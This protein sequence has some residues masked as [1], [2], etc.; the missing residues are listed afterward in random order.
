MRT[1]RSGESKKFS[2]EHTPSATRP[3]ANR[4][5]PL[6]LMGGNLLLRLQ[7]LTLV[8]LMAI[9]NF[10]Q[11]SSPQ[12]VHSQDVDQSIQP[13][14]DFYRFANGK[15][16]ERAAPAAEQT[17]LDIRAMLN[18]R[19]AQRVR[20]LIREAATSRSASG[21]IQQKVGDYYSGFVDQA[22]IESKGLA[23]LAD[24]LKEISAITDN[25]SLSAYLG[26]TLSS[27]IDGLTANADHIFGIWI[28]QG[29]D[30]ASHNLPHI[31]QGGLGLP[32][33]DDYL[34]AS[35]Q[36]SE[37]RSQYQAHIARVLGFAGVADAEHAAAAV[38]S[39]EIGIARAFAPDSDAAD[40]FKQNNPWKR[41]DFD[42]KAP[43]MDWNAYFHSAGLS[44]QEN[45]I[46]WQPSDVI[47]VSALVR[48]ENVDVWKDYLRLHL[49]DHY[50]A[51]LPKE[52]AAEHSAFYNTVGPADA[53]KSDR[54]R[55]A[56]AATNGALGQAVGQLYTQNYFP[57]QAKAKAQAMVRDLTVAYRGR[58]PNLTWMSSE[59]K[60]KALDKLATLQVIVGYPDEWI[61]Y[62][63]LEIVRGDAF[64]NIR[65]A[66][67]FHHSR[68]LRRLRQPV[69]PIDWP[70]NPQ[71]PGAVIM[72]SPNAEFF[73]AGILQPPYFD[74]HGDTAS[75]YG[76]AG[77]AMAHEISHSFDELGDIYDAQGRLGDWWTA[78]DR[79]RYHDAAAKL[80]AQFDAYC[81][82]TDLCVNGKQDLTEN[83]AD[84]TGLEVAH[85]AYIL[86]LKNKPDTIIDGLNGEQRFFLA[87]AQRWR[88]L[89]SEV[90]L[91]HQIQTDTHAPGEFRSDTVR[92]VDGWYNAFKIAPSDKLYLQPAERVR[93]W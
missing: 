33:R 2:P 50:A 1:G 14:Q 40:T 60:Q 28:N 34:D 56:I 25:S 37:V 27:E 49:F 26:G 47:G 69:N 8:A 83:V 6:L 78:N 30:D 16:L 75:N 29:F 77:A 42:L 82:F 58:I 22:A 10:A 65:R 38:L 12:V 57:P 48:S 21:S 84:L 23:P 66:E 81:P 79:T 46:V 5:E 55:D 64:G 41:A 9:A 32:S 67:S 31:W 18:E 45:F 91:R 44:A 51:V 76:S 54:Q 85:D 15:W 20:D 13:G 7:L 87:F 11:R 74:P 61:D 71:Q 92:N 24:C 39:L 19:N 70:I 68:D 3:I 63:S 89:Q 35:P 62:A 88:K 86:S 90:A 73:T 80:A 53:R 17:S 93:I 72:F 4:S 59:T 43:G 36:K 52:V